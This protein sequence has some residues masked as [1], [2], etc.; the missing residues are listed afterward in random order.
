M[1]DDDKHEQ[2]KF[3]H[4]INLIGHFLSSTF[5]NQHNTYVMFS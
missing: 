4:F 2:L 3:P 1:H 5:V